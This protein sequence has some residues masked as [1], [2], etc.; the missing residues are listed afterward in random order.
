MTR[1]RPAIRSNAVLIIDAAAGAH[2]PERIEQE[3]LGRARGSEQI[4]HLLPGVE[5][6]GKW[7]LAL[8]SVLRNVCGSILA[9]AVD[10]QDLH[11]TLPE[12]PLQLRQA[13]NVQVHKRTL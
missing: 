7:E 9:V 4:G 5:Q 6:H 13:K 8:L 11:A 10:R 12:F 2:D 1:R 3:G